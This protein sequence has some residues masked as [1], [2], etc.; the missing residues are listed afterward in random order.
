MKNMRTVAELSTLPMPERDHIQGP[1]GAEIKLIEYGDYECPFCAQAYPIVKETQNRLGKRLCF[2]F[3]NFPLINSHPRSEHA[4]ESAEAAAV[5]GQFW[6][7]H[8]ILFENQG[9]LEDD[10][11]ANYAEA[12]GLDAELLMS[13]VLSGTH[14]LRV[15]EDF[16]SGARFNGFPR[17]KTYLGRSSIRLSNWIQ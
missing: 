17:S 1:L 11:L 9:A 5:Q 4:A 7:M 8:D 6:E 15:G 13:E 3:R 14:V 2:A 10:D 12:L 16:C